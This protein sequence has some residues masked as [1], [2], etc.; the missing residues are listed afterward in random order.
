VTLACIGPTTAAAVESAGWPV[1]VV[2]PDTTADSLVAALA[3]Y[4]TKPLA[5]EVRG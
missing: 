4:L 3:E 2:A 5:A 1:G